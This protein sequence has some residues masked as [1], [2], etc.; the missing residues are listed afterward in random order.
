M[1]ESLE[2]NEERQYKKGRVMLE[3]MVIPLAWGRLLKVMV[4]FLS[5]RKTG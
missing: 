3:G 4:L 2:W 5:H 1:G